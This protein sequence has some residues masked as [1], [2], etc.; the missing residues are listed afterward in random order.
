[1][2][3]VVPGASA[4]IKETGD[5]GTGRSRTM[6]PHRG[7]VAQI[8]S[9]ECEVGGS[10]LAIMSIGDGP[11]RVTQTGVQTPHVDRLLS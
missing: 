10:P 6:S 3:D 4:T 2:H 11:Q 8:T 1:V 9:M 7:S 5:G